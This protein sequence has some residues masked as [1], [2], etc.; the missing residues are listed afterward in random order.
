MT[1]A[2]QGLA[3]AKNDVAQEANAQNPLHRHS[4]KLPA[5]SQILLRIRMGRTES[6]WVH[7]SILT[8]DLE[9][10]THA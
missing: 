7:H 2:W 1:I 4:I 3:S 5:V 10:S 9:R 8:A 6:D